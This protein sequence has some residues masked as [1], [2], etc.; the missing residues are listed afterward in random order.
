LKEKVMKTNILGLR[1]FL[2]RTKF[3]SCRTQNEDSIDQLRRKSLRN[4]LRQESEGEVTQGEYIA[5]FL[6]DYD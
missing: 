1:N 5:T 4:K 6:N 3:P 2:N